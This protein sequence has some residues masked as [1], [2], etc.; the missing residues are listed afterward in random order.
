MLKAS[1]LSNFIESAYI[2]DYQFKPPSPA[3][4]QVEADK[5][6]APRKVT[7][8]GPNRLERTGSLCDELEEY[9]GDFRNFEPIQAKVLAEILRRRKHTSVGENRSGPEQSPS[10][11][12]SRG[13]PAESGMDSDLEEAPVR[14]SS[15]GRTLVVGWNADQVK[16]CGRYLEQSQPCLMLVE[17]PSSVAEDNR[18]RTGDVVYGTGLR[19][20]G[21]L[22]RFHATARIRQEE[23]LLSRLLAGTPDRFDLVLDLRPAAA[24]SF[25]LPPPGYYLSDGDPEELERVLDELPLMIGDF[26]K[27]RFIHHDAESCAHGHSQS[28]ACRSCLDIC[29]ADALGQVDGRIHVDP[30]ACLGCGLCALVC[31]TGAMRCLHASPQDL[32]VALQG[33]MAEAHPEIRRPPTVIFYTGAEDTP[34]AAS[35]GSGDC[36]VLEFPLP[37]IGC[38]GPEVWLAALAYGAG[39]VIL[40]LPQGYPQRLQNALAGQYEWVA[41]LLSGAGLS[42]D[43]IRLVADETPPSAVAEPVEITGPAADF[44]PFQNKRVLIRSS[45]VHLAQTAGGVPAVIHLPRPAPFGAVIVD[46][47]AC[48]LCMA[49]AGGCPT[50][51]LYTTGDMPTLSFVESECIQCGRCRDICPEQALDLEPR[52]VLD[53]TGSELS[54][55][56][57]KQAPF[58]CISCG[59]A[60]APAGL[61]GRMIERLE[62]HWMYSREK[63][64]RRLK[65]CRE[66]RIRDIFREQEQERS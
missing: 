33:R 56:L 48:T 39:R 22:G 23:T 17:K 42:T 38:A 12:P 31:P 40:R 47:S 13:R 7:G 10:Q 15:R 1:G 66:C 50:R 59:K 24:A 11:P 4:P 35:D 57:H 29:P 3:N 8:E 30:A 44:S 51:A 63:D 52:M 18:C 54:Q 25:E 2:M 26:E 36:P 16:A 21:Y 53:P 60:F 41:A 27:P 32:L 5:K 28:A 6:N 43:R 49:C 14:L 19:L 45:I 34:G 65:M 55:V 62:G 37:E 20:R 58:N 64:L 61:V 46:K 9:G